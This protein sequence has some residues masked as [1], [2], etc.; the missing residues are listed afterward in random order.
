M[1]NQYDV[2]AKIY[3]PILYI[4]LQPIRIAV[5]E[6]LAEAK[7]KS[8]LDLCCGTG[9]QL[10][11]LAIKKFRHLHCL[12]LSESMLKIARKSSQPIR[13]YLEDATKTSFKNESFDIVIISFAIHE[14]DR[15]TQ[16]M[17]I[18]E[19]YRILKEKG[20][21]LVVDF[22]FD[23]NTKKI[24][25]FGINVIERIAGKEHFKNFKNYIQN[26]GLLSLINNDKF[27]LLKNTKKFFQSITI[28][29]YQ[30]VKSE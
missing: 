10:K 26:N 25:K 7:D 2:V 27:K 23:N 20:L 6:E 8:I 3:D 21:L 5:L 15:N 12:D 13:T 17:M 1:K 28:S 16:V 14:K 24:G 4:A 30:K 29:K 18:E 9:N 22:V 11:L 19:A